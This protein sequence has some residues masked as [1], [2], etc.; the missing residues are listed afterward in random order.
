MD[1]YSNKEIRAFATRAAR[2]AYMPWGLAEEAGASVAWLERHGLPVV[3]PLLE[4]LRFFQ[5]QDPAT[6]GPK[7]LAGGEER[8][9][10]LSCPIVTGAYLSDLGGGAFDDGPINLASVVSP[11][12]LAPFL[13]WISGDLNKTLT[14]KYDK[15][16]VHISAEAIEIAEGHDAWESKSAQWVTI[17]LEESEPNLRSNQFPRCDIS[18]AQR[19]VLEQFVEMTYL[20]ESEHSKASGAGGG[21]VD[22]D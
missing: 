12:L 4:L 3:Q 10:S 6:L 14:L 17:S 1:T 11:I 9:R 22:D 8:Q 21:S 2:G 7:S 13:V 16:A 19:K 15:V 20:P 5:G 18:D